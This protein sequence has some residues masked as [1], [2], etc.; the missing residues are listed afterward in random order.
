MKYAHLAFIILIAAMAGSC[1]KT[2]NSNNVNSNPG[3]Y[4]T[5]S[6]LDTIYTM[7]GVPSRFV[8]FDASVGSSFYGNS[9]SRYIIPAGIFQDMNGNVISGIVQM[10]VKELLNKG[11]MIF[12][13]ALPVCNNTPLISGGEVYTNATQSGQQLYIRPGYTFQVNI[14]QGKTPLTGM[15]YFCSTLQADP[16]NIVGWNQ[17]DSFGL[18]SI[19]YN[20]DTISI[21]AD[22]LHWIN[23]DRFENSITN[24]S[25][26]VNITIAGGTINSAASVQTYALFDTCRGVWPLNNHVGSYNASTGVYTENYVPGLSVILVS[27]ALI[28]NKFYGGVTNSLK[29]VNKGSYTLLLTQVDPAAFKGQ[30]NNLNN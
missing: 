3:I 1:S 24:E 23:A 27:F 19:L 2:D 20:G 26:N 30:L 17:N 10:E 15:S 16:Q 22:S 21:I 4:S 7:L 12:T 9:G 29:P 6:S 28:N 18:G 5:Y 8:T 25:F 14:P 11:D 13:K